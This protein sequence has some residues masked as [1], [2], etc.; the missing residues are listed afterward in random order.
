MKSIFLT[1]VFASMFNLATDPTIYQF[2][3][4]DI[5]GESISLEAYKGKVVLIVNVASKC[6]LTPQ[7]EDLQTLY[8]QKKDEGL[9][10]LGFPANNFGGQ[11]P[12]TE[13]EINSFCQKNYGVSFPMFSKI[14]VKGDDMHPLYQFLTQKS[15]NGVTDSNVKWN[16]QKYLIGRD[17][18]VKEVISPRNSVLDEGVTDKINALL[19][20]G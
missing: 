10:I 17:G 9:V 20:A 7:Y 6:G 13:E 1:L 14:S 3:M 19:A 12:G 16:F 4:T 2:T 18:K 5:E 8:E 11:E 15:M